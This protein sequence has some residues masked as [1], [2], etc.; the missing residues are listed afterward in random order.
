[1]KKV[2]I[3]S[4]IAALACVITPILCLASTPPPDAVCVI[5]VSP[6][7]A[8]TGSV[9]DLTIIGNALTN[10]YIGG[11]YNSITNVDLYGKT[12]QFVSATKLI[13]HSLNLSGIEATPDQWQVVVKDT[14]TNIRSGGYGV[15][16]PFKVDSP[17][18]PA[19]PYSTYLAEGSTGSDPQTQFE[20]WILVV[21]PTTK[22]AKIN[23]VYNTDKGPVQGPKFTMPP[24][25]R[26][27]VNV[28]D[29][30]KTWSVSTIVQ[31]DQKVYCERS[32]YWNGRTG[33]NGCL[34]VNKIGQDWILP[35]GSTNGG[36]ETWVL[37][38]NPNDTA[39]T[40]QLTF[41]TDKGKVAGPKIKVTAQSRMTV[42]VADYVPS[43]WSVST[44]VSADQNVAVGRSTY[45]NNRHA[46]TSCEGTLLE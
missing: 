23:M 31:S 37:I 12:T 29:T 2:I 15:R 14:T 1:M 39:T 40:A 6:N 4:M 34:G 7:H 8:R 43:T 33:G 38:Q 10:K 27:S 36:F 25:T 35:E 30:V 5:S 19:Y 26:K 24:N 20:T 22:N 9:V 3:I 28:G 32:M 21:N 44:E 46:G 42:N 13:V 18:N 41:I 17:V 11:I 16:I 45:W